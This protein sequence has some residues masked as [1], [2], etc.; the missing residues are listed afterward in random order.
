MPQQLHGVLP[1]LQTPFLD[2]DEIDFAVLQKEVDWAFHQGIGGLGTGM[3]SEVLKLTTTERQS[4]AENLVHLAAGRGPVFMAVGAESARQALEY[5]R[6]AERAGCDA[7]MATPPI[8]SRVNESGLVGYFCTLADGVSVPLIVQDA[9]GYVG[10][11]IP[12]SVYLELL[13]RYGPEKIAFKPEA[14]P[15]GPNLSALRDAT[16]GQ[17]RIF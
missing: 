6:T 9:S 14:A 13:K 12:L 7:V 3:V 4:L 8:S 15:I 16:A 11:A 1:I 5:A 10:Q 2:S 17:A